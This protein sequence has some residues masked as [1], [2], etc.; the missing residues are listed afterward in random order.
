MSTESRTFPAV[1]ENLAEILSWTYV[2]IQRS[3][4][5]DGEQKR[6][7]LALEEAIVNVIEYATSGSPLELTISSRLI[8][9]G[10]LEF[11]LIDNGAPFNPLTHPPQDQRELSLEERKPGGLGLMLIKKCMDAVT[12][13]HEDGRNI[14]TLSKNL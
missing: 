6:V 2:H 13:R 1:R 10:Q 11:E 4:L 9:E 7:Q 12:Y 8:K 3:S 5:A 14:L